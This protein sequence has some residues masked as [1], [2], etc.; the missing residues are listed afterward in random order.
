MAKTSR[1]KA[2]KQHGK[3]GR[4]SKVMCVDADNHYLTEGKYYEVVGLDYFGYPEIKDDDGDLFNIEISEMDA[5]HP[6]FLFVR[7]KFEDGDKATIKSKY[8]EFYTSYSEGDE[9]TIE[10][11]YGKYRNEP[12]Y[13]TKR[14]SDGMVQRIPQ[15]MLKR[16]KSEKVEQDT[17][18]STLKE[19]DKIRI[20]SHS[21]GHKMKLDSIAEVISVGSN[22]DVKVIGKHRDDGDKI[23]Q[24]IAPNTFEI[25][26]SYE[27]D[28]E[29][30]KVGD[31]V[32]A[33]DQERPKYGWGDVSAGDIGKV[34]SHEG[35][36][37]YKVD[38]PAQKDW[39]AN[40]SDIELVDTDALEAQ[41]QVLP[42]KVF[43]DLVAKVVAKHAE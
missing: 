41:L 12:R 18:S 37:K 29:G 7:V 4:G 40:I 17:D 6:A 26:P 38:F 10:Q 43:Y 1:Q 24:I 11:L 34:V 9:V 32:R 22:G 35:G 13:I 8:T 14:V 16:L 21:Y 3:L 19:G 25:I 39:S 36:E 28:V 2:E 33:V 30:F 15:G 27:P 31:Y 5:E 42:E 23:R 20:K